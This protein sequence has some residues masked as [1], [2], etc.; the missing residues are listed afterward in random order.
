MVKEHASAYPPIKGQMS[1][2]HN[3]MRNLF[4][5]TEPSNPICKSARRAAKS[6]ATS[7]RTSPAKP[8]SSPAVR[9]WFCSL[10]NRIAAHV[11]TTEGEPVTPSARELFCKKHRLLLELKTAVDPMTRQNLSTALL[12]APQTSPSVV[13]GI[14]KSFCFMTQA[15]ALEKLPVCRLIKAEPGRIVQPGVVSLVV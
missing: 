6:S 15:N 11:M 12:A 14:V 9:S 1:G 10:G 4:C 8:K 7:P 3:Q 13:K 2:E 5:K